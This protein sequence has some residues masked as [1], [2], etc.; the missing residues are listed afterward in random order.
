MAAMA[1]A[2]AAGG[3]PS[4]GAAAGHGSDRRPGGVWSA[5]WQSGISQ[6]MQL[7]LG[8]MFGRGPAQQNRLT[9]TRTNVFRSRDSVQF[10]GWSTTDLRSGK[11]DFEAGVRYRTPLAK[12][13][14]GTVTGGGGL[15]HWNFQH[16]LGGTRDLALDSYLAW[17]GGEE[18]PVTISANAKTLLLSGLPRGTFLCV[19]ALHTKRLFSTRGVTFALQHGPAYVYSWHLYGKGGNRVLRYY[20]TLIASRGRWSG[21]FM[22]R[23]QAGLQPRIPDNRY[24]SVSIARRFGG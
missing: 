9:A 15:E 5:T 10:Y 2:A 22:L 8:G 24:W 11:P 14:G 7:S 17:S 1:S 23:P 16:V 20:G 13:A 12:V 18:A 3:G 6:G 19:Q 4:A 21:E